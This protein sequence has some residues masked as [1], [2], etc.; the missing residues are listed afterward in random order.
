[1]SA[2]RGFGDETWRLAREADVPAL[3]RAADLLLEGDP[4]DLNYDGH[5][6]RAF[7]L[8]LE[9]RVDDALAQLN[10]GWTEDWPFPAAY[11]ADT[12]RVRYLSGDYER[13]LGALQ[14]AVHGADRLDPAVAEL[15]FAVV[16]RAPRLRLRAVR[17]VL[18]GGTAWQRLRNAAAAASAS[19]RN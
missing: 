12:A 11:A 4:G 3:H 19:S 5:R 14:L 18:G 9:G 7:A 10:E 1:M 2:R 13:S 6:A 15:V 8:A 17:V 16:A